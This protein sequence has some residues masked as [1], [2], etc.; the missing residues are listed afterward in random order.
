MKKSVAI[1]SLIAFFSL[2][3]FAETPVFEISIKDHK[4][5]PDS[6]EVPAGQKVKLLIKNQDASAEEFESHEL[7][8]EKVIAANSE[9]VVFVGPLKPGEYPFFGEFHQDTAKGKI[10]AK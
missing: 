9:G 5:S 10:I 6:I 7:S 4:F 8:R 1:A 2:P 3:A